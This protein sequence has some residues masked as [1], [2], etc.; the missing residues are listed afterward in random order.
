MAISG[1]TNTIIQGMIASDD[2]GTEAEYRSGFID[3]INQVDTTQVKNALLTDEAIELIGDVT[4]SASDINDM[5]EDTS[6][7]TDD[8]NKLD[9]A[10][11]DTD[12][13][14]LLDGYTGSAGDLNALQSDVTASELAHVEGLTGNL[15]N[16]LDN[17]SPGG[18]VYS[19]HT[20]TEDGTYNLTRSDLTAFTLIY[21][22]SGT[23]TVNLPAKTSE[24]D[25][26][27]QSVV[28][29]IEVL[30]ATG[31]IG[32]TSGFDYEDT[33]TRALNHNAR[34]I[35]LPYRQGWVSVQ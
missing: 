17:L 16:Q 4:A 1:R 30:G 12:E 14:N 21:V 25:D 2:R 10:T 24:D 35:Y 9:D 26:D 20:Y 3:I 31:T 5:L 27:F 11:F 15:Q 13:L 22:I 6:F 8:I 32:W 19:F 18:S 7:T 23:V 34:H 28:L 29:A 33:N